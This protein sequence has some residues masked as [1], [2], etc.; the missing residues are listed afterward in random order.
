MSKGRQVVHSH[1]Q[2][3]ARDA[4]VGMPRGI[5]NLGQR[6]A[7]GQGM[8]NKCVPAAFRPRL[9][10]TRIGGENRGVNSLSVAKPGEL[11]TVATAAPNGMSG[12]GAAKTARLA[13][14]LPEASLAPIVTRPGSLDVPPMIS[15]D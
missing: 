15:E 6:S 8:A 9:A 11:P 2:I 1:V 12:V 7:A 3:A 14:G 5:P 4:D 10:V 13:S